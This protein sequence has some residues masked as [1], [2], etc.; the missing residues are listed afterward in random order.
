MGG[1][2][3]IDIRHEVEPRLDAAGLVRSGL[4][5]GLSMSGLDRIEPPGNGGDAVAE[6]A[7]LALAQLLLMVL[8]LFEQADRLGGIMQQRDGVGAG[9]AVDD[10]PAR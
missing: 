4:A 7:D 3:I 10:A 5:G 1:V 8:L 2:G 6:S 9:A